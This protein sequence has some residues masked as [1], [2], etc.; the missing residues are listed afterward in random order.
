MAVTELDQAAL[1]KKNS[2]RQLT[3]ILSGHRAFDGFDDCRQGTSVVLELL[4]AVV[5]FYAGAFTDEFVV[6]AFVRILKPSPAAHVIDEDC[7]ELGFPSLGVFNQLLQ[8][9]ALIEAK[10]AFSIILVCTNNRD[11]ASGGIGM[12]DQRLVFC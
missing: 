9:V 5:D 1:S 3:A 4:R 10:P 7:S 12:I 2:D 8:R 6:R 11:S